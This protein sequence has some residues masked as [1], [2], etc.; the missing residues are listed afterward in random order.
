M[1]NI[2]AIVASIVKFIFIFI[3]YMFIFGIIRMIYMDISRMKMPV[4]AVLPTKFPYLLLLNRNETMYFDVMDFYPLDKSEIT[5]GRGRGCNIS[6]GDLALSA[7]HLR[8]WYEDKEWHAEDL[9]S[10]NGTYLNDELMEEQYL[11]DDGDIIKLGQ[12]DFQFCLNK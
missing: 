10:K 1:M 7:K 3:I 4:R 8:I 9:K 5:L 6:I 12:L 2:S 11:L